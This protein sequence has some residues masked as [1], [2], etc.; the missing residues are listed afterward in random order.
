M[1]Q[2]Q[3]ESIAGLFQLAGGSTSHRPLEE[4]A[5]AG[6][7]PRSIPS[8]AG[9][10]AGWPLHPSL[11]GWL[12]PHPPRSLPS[13]AGLTCAKTLLM[14]S[15]A[16]L[17]CMLVCWCGADGSTAVLLPMHCNA[18]QETG[19]CQ[20]VTFIRERMPAGRS[21]PT[22]QDHTWPCKCTTTSIKKNPNIILWV[23]IVLQ[24]STSL[25]LLLLPPPCHLLFA[26]CFQLSPTRGK[27]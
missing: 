11:P 1:E 17:L 6:A 18:V 16:S 8:Q 12:G 5:P 19:R 21:V 25:R 10:H 7:S 20:G 2:D 4:E 3:C 27:I 9:S 23:V 13:G 26:F 15:P 22:D 24:N 14:H